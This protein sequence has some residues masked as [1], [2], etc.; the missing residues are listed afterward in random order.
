[1][2]MG[3]FEI[4]YHGQSCFTLQTGDSRIIIDP[5]KKKLGEISGDIVYVTHKHLDH[6]AGVNRFLRRNPDS[7]LLC[8]TQVADEFKT[9]DDRIILANSGEEFNQN[10]W[11]FR[12]IRGTHGIFRNSEN[13]GVIIEASSVTFGHAGDTVEFQGFSQENMDIFAIPI[14]GFVTASPK[15]AIMELESFKKP[16]PMIVPMHWL[17]RNPNKFCKKLVSSLPGSKCIIPKSDEFLDFRI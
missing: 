9:F 6:T 13:T 1:M 7:L 5:G 16:L 11:R 15:R 4:K 12:F 10:G 2:I 14:S 3:K 8:N 17:F